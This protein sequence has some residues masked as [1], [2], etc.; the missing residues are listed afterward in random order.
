MLHIFLQ[1]QL[2]Q[3]ELLTQLMPR[4][5]Q[6]WKAWLDRIDTVVNR[7]GGMFSSETAQTWDRNLDDFADKHAGMKEIRH[8]WVEK[9]GWLVGKRLVANMDEDE[10]L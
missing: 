4:L 10:E 6:E 8:S 7:E 3:T 9:V 2:T 1:P 5:L